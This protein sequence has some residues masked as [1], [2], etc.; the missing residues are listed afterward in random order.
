MDQYKEFFLLNKYLKTMKVNIQQSFVVLLAIQLIISKRL[1][2]SSLNKL[3]ATKSNVEHDGTCALL[4]FLL[5]E[6]HIHYLRGKF[7]IIIK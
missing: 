7:G 5:R 3:E 1:V 2:F 4:V 6:T